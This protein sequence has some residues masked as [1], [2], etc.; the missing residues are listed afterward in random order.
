M[1]LQNITTYCTQSDIEHYLS[2]AGVE[3]SVDDDG[4]GYISTD[5]QAA[6]TDARVEASETVNFYC[7]DKYTPAALATSNW[8]NRAATIFAAYRLRSRRGNPVPAIIVDDAGKY[9]E[10]LTL[11]KEANGKIPGVPLRRTLAPVWSN[12][13]CDPRYQFRV[14][15]VERNQSALHNPTQL[16]QNT[17][18]S[19][20]FTF[21]L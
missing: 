10:K 13:R 12:T 9:E 4:D 1:P 15:R 18:Y 16:P 14:I 8:V 21:E 2:A 3:L 17:D 11:I 19:D 20:A 7:W 5:E 6:I